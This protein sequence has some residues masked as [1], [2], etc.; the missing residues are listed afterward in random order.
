MPAFDLSWF[1]LFVAIPY[2]TTGAKLSRVSSRA[3][4]HAGLTHGLVRR[5]ATCATCFVFKVVTKVVVSSYPSNNT[6][7]K[8]SKWK[9]KALNNTHRYS[10]KIRVLSDEI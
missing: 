4:R 10:G 6:H 7:L 9:E 2:L 8:Y 1:S 5:R 3:R